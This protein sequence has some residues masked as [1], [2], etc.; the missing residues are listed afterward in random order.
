[1]IYDSVKYLK[2]HVPEVMLDAEHFLM[3]IKEILNMQ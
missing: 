2:S 3:D 1:M